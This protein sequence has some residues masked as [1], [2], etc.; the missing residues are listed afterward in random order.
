[1]QLELGPDLASNN[2]SMYMQLMGAPWIQPVQ[3]SL[4]GPFAAQ[5]RALVSARCSPRY[6]RASVDIVAKSTCDDC[7]RG[8]RRRD[9][10]AIDS[11]IAQPKRKCLVH[12]GAS[13]PAHDE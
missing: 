5:T 12:L 2:R 9:T 11:Q 7:E 10:Y 6:P 3:F 13:R 4:R 8:L 1:M